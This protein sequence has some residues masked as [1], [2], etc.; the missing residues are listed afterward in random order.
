RRSAG[1][2]RAGGG[3]GGTRGRAGRSVLLGRGGRLGA[4]PA[5][6]RTSRDGV[7]PIGG[8]HGPRR[9]PL[10]AMTRKPAMKKAVVLTFVLLSAGCS[11]DPAY[12]GKRS[13]QW[14]RE[15]QDPKAEVRRAA[16]AG[17][18]EVGVSARAFVPDLAAALK[19]VDE[20]V[21]VRAAVSLWGMG[22]AAA[23]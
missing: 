15:L 2:A 13:S 5:V 8:G 20:G 12:A 7:R 19:D 4:R 17:L 23:P 10:G 21:R 22:P 11:H 14:R 1:G 16:A 9:L 3:I 6:G 18:G